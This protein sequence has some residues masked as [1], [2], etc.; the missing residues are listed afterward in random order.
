[1][2]Q[3]APQPVEHPAEQ[4][5]LHSPVQEAL[6]AILPSRIPARVCSAALTVLARIRSPALT[7]P[8]FPVFTAANTA[9]R[10]L[11]SST[12]GLCALTIQALA[13]WEPML[14]T[15]SR[16]ANASSTMLLYRVTSVDR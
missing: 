12:K 15:P 5:V 13:K 6:Q 8:P 9:Y 10:R 14:P 4:A 11:I 2:P 1:M 7:P 16:L 3:D